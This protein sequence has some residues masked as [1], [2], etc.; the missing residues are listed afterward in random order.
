MIAVGPLMWMLLL[1][2]LRWGQRGDKGRQ[3]FTLLGCQVK[4]AGPVFGTQWVD[5]LRISGNL[6]SQLV[7]TG[8]QHKIVQPLLL[9]APTE[10]ADLVGPDG[11]HTPRDFALGCLLPGQIME[12]VVR[13][14]INQSRTKQGGRISLCADQ[15]NVVAPAHHWE[16]R[17]R[18]L[19]L[20][21]VSLAS[22][23]FQWYVLAAEA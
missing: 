8:A 19:L 6:Q 17:V 12:G 18:E 7:G 23:E 22:L 5:G 4:A 10:A 14:L 15:L 21:Q 2:L 1:E 11:W 3:R 20:E 13:N 9:A 16:W